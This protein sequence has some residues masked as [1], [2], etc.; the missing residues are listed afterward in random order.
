MSQP[1]ILHRPSPR[2]TD[3]YTNLSDLLDIA[4][5]RDVGL[6]LYRSS[7]GWQSVTLT[8][9]AAPPIA[10]TGTTCTA[11]GALGSWNPPTSPIIITS[12]VLY[13]QNPSAGVANVNIG[14]AANTVTSSNTLG[15]TLNTSTANTVAANLAPAAPV[16]LVGTNCVT[17]SSGFNTAGFTGTLYLEYIQP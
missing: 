9:R 14:V 10:L 13:V 5:G 2:L 1:E 7:L 17:V 4:V 15:A 12:S 16:L 8:T 6:V 3:R 11:G